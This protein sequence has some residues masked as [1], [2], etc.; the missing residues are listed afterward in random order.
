MSIRLHISLVSFG[1][2]V[3]KRLTFQGKICMTLCMV[4]QDDVILKPLRFEKPSVKIIFDLLTQR[5]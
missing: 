4:L 1:T 3:K 5:Y 2:K